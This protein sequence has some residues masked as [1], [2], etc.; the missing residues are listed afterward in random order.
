MAL[1]HTPNCDFGRKIPPFALT[2]IDGKIHDLDAI[3][4]LNGT[5]VMFICNHCPYVKAIITRLVAD[6]KVLQDE[7][8][9]VAA[10]MPN[11]TEIVE[12]DN[13]DNMA[14]FAKTHGFTFPYLIDETQEVALAFDAVC[15]PDFFGFNTDDELHYRGRLDQ[16]GSKLAMNNPR[17]ELVEAMRMIIQTGQGPNDQ[18]ASIG[19]SI[20]WRVA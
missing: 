4:G 5:L 19:C 14:V 12:A 17:R 18:I 3:H 2:G 9:G 6:V 11:A 13:L 15:T 10:I 7:G 16:S 1:L 20:K 8:I